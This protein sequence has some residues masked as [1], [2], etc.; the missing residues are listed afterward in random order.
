MSDAKRRALLPSVLAGTLLLGHAAADAARYTEH[1][2]DL[3]TEVED[4]D[5]ALEGTLDKAQKKEKAAYGKVKKALLAETDSLVDEIKVAGKAAKILEKAVPG[6]ET[7]DA[8]LADAADALAADAGAI[9][10][11]LDAEVGDDEDS[12]GKTKALRAIDAAGTYL[13]ASEGESLVSMRLKLMKKAVQKT[14]PATRYVD[15][16]GGGGGGG[17]GAA[18]WFGT[19]T[20]GAGESATASWDGGSFTA[21]EAAL[22]VMPLGEFTRSSVSYYQC[23]PEAVR[24]FSIAWWEPPAVGVPTLFDEF[25]AT[26]VYFGEGTPGGILGTQF[27]YGTITLTESN[28]TTGTFAGTFEFYN[29]LGMEVENGTF[30]IVGLQ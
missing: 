14:T 19:R 18:C 23:T 20:L 7:F 25:S 30:R 4:R 16:G 2:D 3:E 6:D 26:T 22:S 8:L 11:D 24:M 27:G 13:D 12:K 15:S 10:D 9:L 17:G 28:A 21:G 1:L 5:A 29:G